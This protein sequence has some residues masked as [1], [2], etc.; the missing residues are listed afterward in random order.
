MEPEGGKKQLKTKV[1]CICIF[2]LR[3]GIIY[4]KEMDP[5]P[6]KSPNGPLS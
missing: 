3:S 5:S 1:D 6:E 4:V 2:V